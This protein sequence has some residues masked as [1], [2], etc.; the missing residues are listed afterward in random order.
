M[1]HLVSRLDC[2]IVN[3]CKVV[4]NLELDTC[5][6]LKLTSRHFKFCLHFSSK[7]LSLILR[8]DDC[9]VGSKPTNS[10]NN[11]PVTNSHDVTIH[12]DQ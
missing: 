9:K 3:P 11:G 2:Y 5:I 12:D 1:Y 10:K 4:Y 8:G 6:S 7:I